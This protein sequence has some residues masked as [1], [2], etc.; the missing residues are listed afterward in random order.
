[1]YKADFS[2]ENKSIVITGASK[3]IG[4]GVAE[5]LAAGG[6]DVAICSR[7]Q[8]RITPVAED[9]EDETDSRCLAVECNVRHREEVENLFKRTAEEFGRIDVLINNA[10]GEFLSPFEEITP[11]GWDSIIDLN[12]N[13]IFHC[14]QVAGE[15]MRDGDGGVVLNV[16]SING[17]HAAPNETHYS[18]SK[19]AIIRLTETLAVEWAEHG[20]RVVCVAP[21]LIQTPGVAETIGIESTDMPPRETVDRRIGH[22]KEIADL[23][24]FLASPAASFVNG[25]TITARGVPS[26]GNELDLDL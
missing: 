24:Q 17:Q 19:A 26:A 7:S 4:K 6:A 12:L 22:V 14:T 10:G 18:A 2:V 11:N 20:I 25:E 9:I 3:G 21:G 1:M 15:Y 16:S 23:I 8:D 13:S 5:T